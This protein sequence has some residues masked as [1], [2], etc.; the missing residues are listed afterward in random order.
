MGIDAQLKLT[1][2]D[3]SNVGSAFFIAF[4]IAEVPTGLL[5]SWKAIFTLLTE[6][7]QD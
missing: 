1:K 2:N 3:F 4:L 5:R 6:A 7:I